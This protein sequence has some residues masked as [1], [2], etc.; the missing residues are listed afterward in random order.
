MKNI[1]GVGLSTGDGQ[2]D[3]VFIRGFT[4]IG[5]QFVDGFRDDAL[6][7]RDLSNVERLEV[8]KGPAA[9]LYGRGSSGGLVNRITKKPGRHHGRGLSLTNTAGRRGE[10]DVGRVGETV[11]WRSRA[12][13]NCPT[14]TATSNSSTARR[15]RHPWP[16]ACPAPPSCCCRTTWKTAA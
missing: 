12:R 7:F 6:Y 10:V 16:S 9:V 14:A 2:R 3:Q 13:A 1:P 5:D 15:W 11:D 4:A 8:I